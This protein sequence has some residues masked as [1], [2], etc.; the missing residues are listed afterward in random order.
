MSV[1]DRLLDSIVD[2]IGSIAERFAIIVEFSIHR[3]AARCAAIDPFLL[4]EIA[5]CRGGRGIVQSTQRAVIQTKIIIIIRIQFHRNAIGYGVRLEEITI[6][7]QRMIQIHM[8]IDQIA[9]EIRYSKLGTGRRLWRMRCRRI[10]E[11]DLL[12][13][14]HI[15]GIVTRTGRIEIRF[16]FDDGRCGQGR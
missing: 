1:Q 12:L 3:I 9:I 2:K 6:W 13:D 4:D 16:H 8:M 7:R 14:E 10:L 5:I 11:H 15:V